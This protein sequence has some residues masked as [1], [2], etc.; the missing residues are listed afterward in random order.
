MILLDG[1]KIHYIAVGFGGLFLV[2]QIIHGQRSGSLKDVST[3]TLFFIF[4]SSGIWGYYMYASGLLLYACITGFINLNA[5][6][7]MLM[8]LAQYYLRF[9]KHVKTFEASAPAPAPAPSV[10]KVELNNTKQEEES[11]V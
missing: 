8:Q 3:A 11:Q 2:P 10:V 7:L 6:I 5:I 1:E 4:V 9:K